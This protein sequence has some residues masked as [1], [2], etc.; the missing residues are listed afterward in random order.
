MCRSI[1]FPISSMANHESYF[2][3]VAKNRAMDGRKQPA[4]AVFTTPRY[5]IIYDQG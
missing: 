4:L 1:L 3:D 2:A 5:Y